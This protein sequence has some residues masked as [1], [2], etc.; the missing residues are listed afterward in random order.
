MSL[1][2]KTARMARATAA[3]LAVGVGLLGLLRGA[4]GARRLEED[5]LVGALGGIDGDVRD[6]RAVETLD[7]LCGQTSL[8]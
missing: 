2:K 1:I 3:V 4:I 8:G 6:H 5:F 7:A